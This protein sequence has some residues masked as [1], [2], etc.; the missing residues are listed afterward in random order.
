M[1]FFLIGTAGLLAWMAMIAATGGN[2]PVPNLASRSRFQ[3]TCNAIPSEVRSLATNQQRQAFAVCND[4]RL[5]QN[6]VTFG[7][8]YKGATN[9][10][11][12]DSEVRKIIRAQLTRIRDELRASRTALEAIDLKPG[13][14]L[15]LK[16]SE[17]QADLNEDGKIEVWEKYLFAIPMRRDAALRIGA[18]SSDEQYYRAEFN[19]EAEILVDQS[20]IAW[21]LSYHYFVES[22]IETVL[23]YTL[24]H[25]R[26]DDTFI[27]LFDPSAMRRAHQL[28][29]M[30]LKMSDRSRELVEAEKEDVDEWIANESQTHSVFP[31]S[32]DKSDFKTWK[33]LLRHLIPLVEGKTVLLPNRELGGILGELAKACP[34]GQGLNIAQFYRNPPKYPAAAFFKSDWSSVCS[35]VGSSHPVSGLAEFLEDYDHRSSAENGAGM[36]YLRYL[37]WVN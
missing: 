18:A 9:R 23:A 8:K 12:T 29:L 20:D 3:T 2:K 25:Q 26:M 34:V 21:A 13:E 36:R 11:L 7:S 10:N 31:V 24:N 19:L 6:I 1:R 28:M 22:L 33:E 17:W 27:E 37:L 30:G 15:R 5:V 35:E 4:I 32:L 16:P 14:G